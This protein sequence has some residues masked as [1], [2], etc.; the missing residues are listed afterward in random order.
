MKIHRIEH[1]SGE[2]GPYCM[3]N[4]SLAM[5]SFNYNPN[6]IRAYHPTVS[7]DEALQKQYQ[8]K[9]GNPT[10]WDSV[11]F[12]SRFRFGY[13]SIIQLKNW[14]FKPSI[15]EL[16]I[17]RGFVIQEY[18]CPEEKVAMSERQFLFEIAHARKL[19]QTS[20]LKI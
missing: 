15:I 13:K 14:M 5:M 19:S 4:P 2:Y 3:D 7:Q 8:M 6:I 20:L 9:F 11:R 16:L 1:V 18:E 17:T 10:D 12:D